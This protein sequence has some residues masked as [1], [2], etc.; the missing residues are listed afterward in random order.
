M[1][2]FDT[3]FF[4]SL[5]FWEVVS[6]AIL[7][8]VLYKY[9]FP[10]ILGTLEARERKIRETL[11]QAE[12]QRADA[13][14]RLREYETKL[15][16]A[17]EEANAMVAE[18]KTRAQRVLE[19]NEQRML[20]DAERIKADATREIDH[21]RRRALS[22][23]RQQAVDLALLA[24]EKLVERSLTDQDHRRLAEEALSAVARD[25]GRS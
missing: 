8:F 24:A 10:P 20:A 7:L 14:R 2:Q 11:E 1:P 18:A 15:R 17:S 13:E 12:R 5:L 19:E 25:H 21:E 23:I 16:A 6:F 4:S 3:A 9:A 22:E